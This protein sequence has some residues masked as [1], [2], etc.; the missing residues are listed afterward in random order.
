MKTQ[1]CT[2]TCY[3][4]PEDLSVSENIT[5]DCS[6]AHQTPYKDAK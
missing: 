2:L 6:N 5:S 4:N 1:K 3:L